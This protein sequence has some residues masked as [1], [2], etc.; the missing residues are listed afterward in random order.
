LTVKSLDELAEVASR[1]VGAWGGLR[2][3][4]HPENSELAVAY[5][6]DGAIIEVKVRDLK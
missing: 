2:M 3:V 4:L 5:S 1:I 6:F